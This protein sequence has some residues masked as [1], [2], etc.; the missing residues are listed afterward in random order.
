[1]SRTKNKMVIVM[2]KDLQMTK[3]K[4]VAQGSHASLGLVLDIQ[5]RDNNEHKQVLEDWLSDSFTKVAVGVQSED[6][7][8]KLYRQAQDMNLATT[9]ITDNGWTMFNGVKT[10]TCISILGESNKIDLITGELKL[11]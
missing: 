9:L 7:L 3:G 2:R 10:N 6:E 5:K 11:L 4:Y 1:M 8:L